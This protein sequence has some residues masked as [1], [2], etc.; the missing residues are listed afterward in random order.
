M[1]IKEIIYKKLGSS[2]HTN[3]NLTSS[4]I[5]PCGMNCG[6]CLG[7]HRIKNKCAGC[8]SA[9]SNKPNH[10]II[11]SIKNCEL[12]SSRKSKFCFTC[13]KYPCR[14]IK[15][16]D[17][18]YRSKYG[19]SMIENL[20][21]IKEIGVRIFILREKQKWACSKCGNII[22]V[23]REHCL[24]CGNKREVAKYGSN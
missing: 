4:L 22:C 13:H 21:T 5:A 6:L 8:Q 1:I 11:C 20:N 24:V 19:M 7:Y 2:L 17:K 15:K 3:I 12:L 10:C 18:R 23:H 16:L 9:S 14:R